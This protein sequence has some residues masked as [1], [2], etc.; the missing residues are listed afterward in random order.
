M[1]DLFS[2]GLIERIDVWLRGDPLMGWEV[3][4]ILTAALHPHRFFLPS[5][6]LPKVLKE[7][8]S[9]RREIV[10]EIK[11]SFEILKAN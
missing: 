3:V 2:L 8:G 5:A 10:V 7:Q 6:L 1:D 9:D 4:F 11:V